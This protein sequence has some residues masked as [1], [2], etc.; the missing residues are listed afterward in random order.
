MAG[1]PQTMD[2]RGHP[3]QLVS[4]VDPPAKQKHSYG[5]TSNIC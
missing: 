5:Y 4:A 2:T 1:R 3:Q